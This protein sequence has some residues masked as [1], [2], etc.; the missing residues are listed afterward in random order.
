M[1]TILS[2]TVKIGSYELRNRIVM[3]PL[4]RMRAGQGF[5]PTDLT[6]EYYR[7]RASA[8]L[9]IA[10]GSQISQQGQ[11]FPGTP[12][13]YTQ[14]QVAGWKKV[15]DAVHKEGGTLFLQLWHV[16]RVSHSTLQ[17]ENR[18]PVAPSPLPAIGQAYR[19]DYSRADFEIPHTLTVEE[20][21]EIIEDYRKAA[22]NAK[23]AGFDGVEI[24]GANG[25]LIE[26]F[27][28]TVSNRREDDYG[29]S[30]ENRARL[31][32]EVVEAVLSV[33][34]AGN[35]GI[36]ISP[37]YSGNID[38]EPD[39]YPQY[40]HVVRELAPFNLAY[41]HV[42]ENR[43]STAILLPGQKE[44]HVPIE[45]L[46]VKRFREFYKSPM[47]SAG[48]FTKERAE[49]V[50]EKGYAEAIAFGRRFISNPDLPYR[51]TNGL[52]LNDY[53]RS[54]FY[55]GGEKGYTD[56]PALENKIYRK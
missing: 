48:G 25:Y 56:Y 36:R 29:G 35:T 27:L 1:E 3:P 39:P 32:L 10:E 5:V 22:I 7:Q 18:L 9:I 52:T 44:T 8:G 19:S 16:G 4:T 40:D 14:E 43:E 26:E 49:E 15:T 20:I 30:I 13:I 34:P 2:T 51:L 31:L 41:L 24:H 55:G 21:K 38:A 46:S 53:D 33:W 54:T 11:G 37:F 47:I 45:E 42:I 12:G 6:V 23:E 28:R 17:P 50:L